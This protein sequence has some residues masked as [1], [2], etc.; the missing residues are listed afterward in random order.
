MEEC[1]LVSSEALSSYS[2]DNIIRVTNDE[3][4][5]NLPLQPLSVH[6]NNEKRR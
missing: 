5:G 6:N 2:M 3:D 4:E 1:A